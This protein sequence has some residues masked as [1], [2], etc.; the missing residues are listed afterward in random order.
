MA[1]P[2]EVANSILSDLRSTDS[3]RIEGGLLTA[4]FVLEQTARYKASAAD[5]DNNVQATPPDR[6][7]WLARLRSEY[8]AYSG[9]RGF[10]AEYVGVVLP[11]SDVDTIVRALLQY[12]K[13]LDAKATNAIAAIAVSGRV[14][15]V[16]LL[17]QLVRDTAEYDAPL[18]R[19]AIYAMSKILRENGIVPGAVLASDVDWIMRDAVE[20]L[21][22]AAVS[23]AEGPLRAREQAQIELASLTE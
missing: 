16:P 13:G 2:I 5:N 1:N 11:D 17:A 10:P 7:E 15:V 19:D 12:V 8:E 6:D 22:L 20:A 14:W 9:V 4:F 21:Q 23:G 3:A 18:A